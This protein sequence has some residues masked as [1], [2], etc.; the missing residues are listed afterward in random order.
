MLNLATPFWILENQQNSKKI[1][2]GRNLKMK[3][4]WKFRL[5]FLCE[6]LALTYVTLK[7][8]IWVVSFIHVNVETT[9]ILVGILWIA[10][11]IAA[12]II[13]VIIS[14]IKLYFQYK[15]LYE[16]MKSIHHARYQ[17]YF[18]ADD[19]TVTE[20]LTNEIM[21][22]ARN[23]LELGESMQKTL[24]IRKLRTKVKEMMKKAEEMRDNEKVVY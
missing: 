16:T 10:F 6:V 1:Y 8:A 17:S 23:L 3:N 9:A 18:S 21:K 4:I 5:Y 12:V 19:V 14:K 11:L 22:C 2:L 13:D 7:M 24:H 20:E 15:E